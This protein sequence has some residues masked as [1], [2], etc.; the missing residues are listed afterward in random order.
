MSVHLDLSTR[1]VLIW[2]VGTMVATLLP[3]DFAVPPPGG[4][5]ELTG[6]SEGSHQQDPAHVLL[7]VLLFMPFGILVHFARRRPSG[8]VLSSLVLAGTAACLMSFGIE[9]LQVFLPGRESS[10]VDVSA[11]TSGALV[12]VLAGRA[13]QRS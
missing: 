9:W 3:F 6:F 10:L 13:M 7:N 4:R 2:L 8:N 11:N 5:L 12:G 1:L